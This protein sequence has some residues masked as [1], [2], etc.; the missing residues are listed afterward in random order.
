MRELETDYLVVGAGAA[1]LAF[2][3]SLISH[4]NADVII[5]DRRERPGGH[6]N[7]A[8]PFL[9]LHQRSAF[10]GVS[11]RLLGNDRIDT[12]GPNAGFYERATA[13]EVC[14]YFQA[15]LD[16]VLLPSR[17]VRFFGASDLASADSGHRFTSLDTGASHEVVV[18]RKVVDATFLETSVP[19]THTPTFTVDPD[20]RMVPVAGVVDATPP[21]SSR[22]VLLGGGKTAMDTCV[23]LLD[24]GVDPDH[25]RWV[26]PRDSWLLDRAGWQPLDQVVSIMEGISLELEAAARAESVP[27]LFERLEE[28]GRL[29]RIDPRVVPTMYRCATVG[30]AELAQL[31]TVRDVVRLGRVCRI[32]RD[33]MEFQEGSVSADPDDLYVDCTAVGLRHQPPRPVFEQH[34]ITIQQIRYCSPTFNAALIAYLEATREDLTEL[35]RLCPATP[36][37]SAAADW[38]PNFV[39]TMTAA[40]RWLKDP[41]LNEWIEKSRLNLLRG[42]ADQA[43][44][45][46]MQQALGR[47]IEFLQPGIARLQELA[48]PATVAPPV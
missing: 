6:W 24:K 17:R 14:D 31:R 8:Y 2:V 4:S 26:R 40:G 46:R 5:V 27:N 11:S 36:Y 22:Y 10:Y 12:D 48:V 20:V 21:S 39:N 29:V 37:P 35:N 45:P 34:R 18:R 30:Q 15:V 7:D 19:A 43:G 33:R 42:V 41:E 16:E 32:G 28:C 23:W 25:I 1:G 47:Y 38:M 13:A 3:D 44:D 9:R